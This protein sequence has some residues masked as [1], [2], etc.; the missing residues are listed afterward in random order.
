MLVYWN[1]TMDRNFQEVEEVYYWAFLW[2]RI[3]SKKHRA[4]LKCVKSRDG[5]G[6]VCACYVCCRKIG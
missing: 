3:A 4:C 6:L 5:N 1:D 2:S